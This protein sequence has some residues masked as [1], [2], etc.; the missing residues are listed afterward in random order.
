MSS[1]EDI[2]QVIDLLENA[3]SLKNDTVCSFIVAIIDMYV[4]AIKLDHLFDRKTL[5][6]ACVSLVLQNQLGL[7]YK[8]KQIRRVIVLSALYEDITEISIYSAEKEIRKYM[9]R[10][11]LV[12]KAETEESSHIDRSVSEYEEDYEDSPFR[13]ENKSA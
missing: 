8:E 10:Q 9:K 5:F 3:F 4:C 13:K 7:E 2:Q 11:L 12:L 6:F 1:E